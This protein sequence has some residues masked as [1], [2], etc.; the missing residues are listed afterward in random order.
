VN[1]LSLL[2]WQRY[3]VYGA[4]VLAIGAA[5][6]MHGYSR[7]EIK[8]FEYKAEQARAAVSIIRKIEV[9]K[10]I[11]RV[12]YIK[13]ET[14]IK[15]VFVT[16]EKEVDRVPSR[17]H[18]NVTAG[19]MRGHNSAASGDGRDEGALD[20]PGDTGI[21][22]ARALSVVQANYKAYHLVANDLKACRAYVSAL[23]KE[24]Q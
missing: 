11:I 15:T 23:A 10:Q 14:Q 12:P 19:W 7:G 6:W 24:T 4:L 17:P 16:I 9:Q 13:R 1:P 20:D 21:A 22:E 3:V 8:L 5:V 2:G 18:C